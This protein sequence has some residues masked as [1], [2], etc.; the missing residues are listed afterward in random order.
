MANLSLRLS[1]SF[2]CVTVKLVVGW[3]RETV[4]AHFFGGVHFKGARIGFLLKY[5][6][7]TKKDEPEKM[8][9]NLR[10]TLSFRVRLS[11]FFA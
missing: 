11:S 10:L 3:K 6:Q 7:K 8:K 1:S 5:K 9:K 2:A 4:L